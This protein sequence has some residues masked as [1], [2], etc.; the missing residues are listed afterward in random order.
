MSVVRQPGSGS[1]S[2]SSVRPRN[3]PT[4]VQKLLS[5]L[6]EADAGIVGWAEEGRSF[7]VH[8]VAAF[9]ARVLPNYVC[10]RGGGV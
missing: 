8:D 7:N 6:D 5:V 1:R 2:A 9:S 10:A 3:L 4:F